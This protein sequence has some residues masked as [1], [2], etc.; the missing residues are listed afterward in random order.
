[1]AIEKILGKISD[2]EYTSLEV[3]LVLLTSEQMAKGHQKLRSE[4]GAELK[5]SLSKGAVLEDGDVLTTNDSGVVAVQAAEEDIISVSSGSKNEWAAAAYVLGNL[6]KPV[7]FSAEAI[8]TPYA[9]E[10]AAALDEAGIHYDRA[11]DRLLGRR[12]R[13]AGAK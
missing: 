10:S 11:L 3:D 6:H 12:I 1:M 13:A 8:R 5:V 4:S 7:R 2:P 9:P